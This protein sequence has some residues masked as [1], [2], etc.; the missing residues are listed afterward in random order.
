MDWGTCCRL[1]SMGSQRVGCDWGTSL[2]LSL[3]AFFGIAL[4]WDWN[5]NRC[6]PVLWPLLSFPIFF[7]EKRAVI[8]KRLT[9][10]HLWVS[11]SL[12]Q[13][14]GLK[15]ACYM[16]GGPECSCVYTG[17]FKEASIIFITSTIV[18]SQV[19]QHRENTA[20]KINKKLDLLSMAPPI[21]TRP[22]FSHS[23]YLPSR[24]FHKSVILQRADRMKTMITEK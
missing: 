14:H 9:Q 24:S 23:Q 20:T 6:F 12:Q 2:S 11:R 8:H 17:H 5:E 16:V 22:S 18:W 1:L 13:R 3:W 19:K 4:L 15:V 10:I 21:R 7:Q